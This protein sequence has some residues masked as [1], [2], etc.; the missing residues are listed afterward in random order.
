[1]NISKSLFK[2]YTR[3]ANF[4][5][6]YDMYLF[7]NLHHVKSVDGVDVGHQLELVGE[8]PEGIFDEEKEEIIEIFSN[9]FDEK[10]GEDLT[11]ITNAQLEA[12]TKHLSKSN[13]WRVNMSQANTRETIFSTLIPK[14]KRNSVFPKTETLI[15]VIWISILSALTIP[16][17]FLKLNPLPQVNFTN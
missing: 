5:P 15:T 10:T 13:N 6:L 12:Y 4:A 16:L 3:C 8:I 17:R 7:R 1:M 2:N 14:S 9:M 11:E